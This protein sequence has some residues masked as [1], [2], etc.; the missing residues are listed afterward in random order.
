M[1]YSIS[2]ELYRRTAE[3]LDEAIGA[4]DYF[5]GALEIPFGRVW[6]RLVVSVIVYRRRESLPEGDRRPVSDLVPVWWEFRTSDD[7]EE[8]S[9][10]FSFSELKSYLL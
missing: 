7:G 6:C 9:N 10:D 8:V 5:S 4:L 3:R 1:M 2:P